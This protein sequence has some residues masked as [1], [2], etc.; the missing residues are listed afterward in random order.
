LP[1]CTLFVSSDDLH[2]KCAPLFLR[3]DQEFIWGIDLKPAL[4]NINAHFLRLPEEERD[5]GI[6]AFA[7]APPPG[8]LVSD[9]WDRHLRPGYRDEKP[10]TPN[11]AMDAE[12]VKLF[13]EFREQPTLEVAEDEERH[14]M[15]SVPHTVRHK[16]GSWWQLPHLKRLYSPNRSVPGARITGSRSRTQRHR[17][18]SARRTK[19]GALAMRGPGLSSRYVSEV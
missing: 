3:R 17:R 15:I 19:I 8:N 5:R 12:L 11:P 18:K 7:H 6:S 4:K 14:E 13:K 16:R 2:R 10:I 9:L 1:F